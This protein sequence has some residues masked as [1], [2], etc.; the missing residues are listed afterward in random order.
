MISLLNLKLI[1]NADDFGWNQENDKVIM[2]MF[3]RH[4]ITSASVILN[5]SNIMAV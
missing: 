3:H 5:G 1:I 2:D 4:T